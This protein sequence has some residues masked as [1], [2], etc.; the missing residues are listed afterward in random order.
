MDYKDTVFSVDDDAVCIIRYSS[1]DSIKVNIAR[2]P[3]L[4]GDVVQAPLYTGNGFT[5]S[6]KGH[7]V[8]E[9]H[10]PEIE[11]L[12]SGSKIYKLKS[13]GMLI[14]MAE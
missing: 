2:S 11:K 9:F 3:E 12:I 1:K 4:G 14:E 6:T 7:I 8:P 5:K 13:D 10:Q